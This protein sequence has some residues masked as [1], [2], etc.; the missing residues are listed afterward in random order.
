M[1]SRSFAAFSVSWRTCRP[2]CTGESHAPSARSKLAGRDGWR[3]RVG[4]YRVLYD[5]D[6]TAHAVMIV[7]VGHRRDVYR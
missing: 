1:R 3:I 4:N 7:H 2:T 6:D 5:I